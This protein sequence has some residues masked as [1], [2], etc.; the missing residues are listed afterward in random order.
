MN[1]SETSRNVKMPAGR[2]AVLNRSISEKI[3]ELKAKKSLLDGDRKAYE[4]TSQTLINKNKEKIRCLR[5][6]N[7]D[8]RQ[9]LQD[10]NSKDEAVINKALKDKPIERASL[11]NKTGQEAITVLDHKVSDGIK[12]LNSLKHQV[13]QK[14][15]QLTELSTKFNLQV[16]DASL[17]QATDK[18]ESQEAQ[19]IRYLENS[20]DKARLKIHEADHLCHTYEQILHKLK[21]D[22]LTWP[23]VLENLEKQIKQC[24]LEH[25]ELKGMHNDA[26]LSKENALRDLKKQEDLV[27]EERK[28]R[29]L[30]L[31]E[32]RKEAEEKKML[33][34]RIERRF[35]S[36][37]ASFQQDEIG[38]MDKPTLSGEE[39]Q[40]KITTYE[41]AFRRIKEATGVSDTM[42]V[43]YR[44]EN[45]GATTAHLEELKREN[46]KQIVRLQEEKAALQNKFEEMKYTGESKLSSGQ[47]ML[48]D[49]QEE[50]R[51]EKQNRNEVEEKLDKLS[52]V[53]L[54]VKAGVDH[55]ADKL[56]HLKTTKGHTTSARIS[57][58]SNEYVLDQLAL[59][60]EK[61]LKLMDDFGDTDLEKI[62]K[63]MEDEE[64][65]AN[66]ENRLPLYNTRVKLPFQQAETIYGADSESGREDDAEVLSRIAIKKQS[67]ELID[68]QT[69]KC[70]TRR[71][72]KPK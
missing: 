57:P 58:M 2:D 31:Q 26:Q 10:L 62:Q 39:Q 45:Q 16:K 64:F 40:Q 59:C 54:Q 23:L 43:V 35:N 67:K 49:F 28:K 50:L 29:D 25:E 60:E 20:C 1:V 3:E 11:K 33:H 66:M 44:F 38:A 6:D 21:E 12:Q 70:N 7:K 27:A 47:K 18:G 5:K 61:L 17:A 69:K 4:E 48:E 41:E 22:S 13:A 9:K 68:R 15:K 46:E 72:K 65:H 63:H 19:R 51:K 42:E 24:Q 53:L 55:L 34:E 56:S 8:L 37:R 30:A 52:K 36:Q 71:R 14:K 32:K